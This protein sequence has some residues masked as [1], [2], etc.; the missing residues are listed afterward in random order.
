MDKLEQ[1]SLYVAAGLV[2]YVLLSF[3]YRHFL[4]PAKRLRRYGTWAVVTGATD[5]IGR[6]IAFELAK[7]KLNVLI[8]SR[9]DSKLKEVAKEIQQ[10]YG[11]VKVDTLA[12]DYAALDDAAKQKIQSKIDDIEVGV[13]V[14][15]VGLSYTHPEYFHSLSLNDTENLIALNVT[16]VSFMSHIVLPQMVSRK[17]GLIV[18]MS[19]AAAIVPSPLLAQYGAVKSYVNK[20]SHSLSV[21]YASYGIDVQV[22]NALYV[23][24]K[25]AKMRPSLQ[26]PTAGQFARASVRAFGYDRQISPYWVHAILIAFIQRM[27]SFVADSY[28]MGMHKSIRLRALKKAG[29]K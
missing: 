23:A 2:S 18:N 22:Q 26:T 25:M 15:N 5:G 12:V 8:I 28:L 20:F 24:T 7:Q 1:T 11:D 29:K 14:N 3:V 9:T 21:E 13:L 19:S 16:S 27:P 6:A 4:R 10:K 17:R